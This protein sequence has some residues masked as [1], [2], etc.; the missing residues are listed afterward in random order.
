[1]KNRRVSDPTWTTKERR[2]VLRAFCDRCEKAFSNPIFENHDIADP[3]GGY[4]FKVN[5]TF[6][7]STG[8]Q[9]DASMEIHHYDLSQYDEAIRLLRPFTLRGEDVYL[10]KIV[11]HLELLL[12]SADRNALGNIA[13]W[14]EQYIS[15]DKEYAPRFFSTIIANKYG[16]T[17]AI[18]HSEDLALAYIYGE[19]VKV[20]LDKKEF[21]DS[22]RDPNDFSIEMSLAAHLVH[23]GRICHVVKSKIDDLDNRHLLAE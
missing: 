10:P 1:M 3:S 20:D 2:M 12:D 23:L 11:K 13:E 18:G 9:Q 5:V 7:K 22:F 6:D 19:S 14:L 4:N 15:F 16:E 21:L 8:S 17:E